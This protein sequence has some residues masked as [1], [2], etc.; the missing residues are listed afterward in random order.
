MNRFVAVLAVVAL[1]A[2][3]VQFFVYDAN[4]K[5]AEEQT[6]ALKAQLAD[7]DS[8]SASQEERLAQVKNE[9]DQ[10]RAV[11]SEVHKLRAEITQLRNSLQ[12]EKVKAGQN[13]TT[14]KTQA[15]PGESASAAPK[16]PETMAE[17]AQE[18]GKLRNKML[19]GGGP[20]T[21]Q[22]KQWLNS[23]KPELEK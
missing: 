23:L 4:M 3:G 16:T 7:A 1:I 6:A 5:R 12:A 20:L 15:I 22:E 10:T 19:G 9:L 21:D 13:K 14:A 18:I 11:A 2:V 17:M 8:K